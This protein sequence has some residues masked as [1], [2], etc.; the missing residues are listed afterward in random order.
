MQINYHDW[1]LKSHHYLTGTRDG[2]TTYNDTK[3][4]TMN[5]R[6]E[7]LIGL[8]SELL[9][10]QPYNVVGN[11]TAFKRLMDLLEKSNYTF[12]D[13]DQS[14]IKTYKMSL[15]N[16]MSSMVVNT[17]AVI[18]HYSSSDKKHVFHGATDHYYI[19][20]VPFNQLHF[21]DRDE[22]V[23][24]RL[25]EFHE[26][27]NGY[28]MDSDR[29]LSSYISDILGFTLLCTV[30]GFI[31]ND[32]K[33]AIDEKGFKFKIGWT[34]V[35]KAD[36]IIYK[37]D[38]TF[39]ADVD[40][41]KEEIT[42]MMETKYL[43][44]S[45]LKL[46]DHPELIGS[47]CIFHLCDSSVKN[48]VK[49][50]PNFGIMKSNGLDVTCVQERI[51]TDMEAGS[52]STVRFRIYALK[53]LFEIPDLYP[54]INFYSVIARKHIYDSK[55]NHITNP[56]GNYIITEYNVANDSSGNDCTPPISVDRTDDKLMTPFI[57]AV[58]ME[59]SLN[60]LWSDF[61]KMFDTYFQL[62]SDTYVTMIDKVKDAADNAYNKIAGIYAQYLNI[63]ITTN[64]VDNASKNAFDDFMEQ[65]S[66]YYEKIMAAPAM[67]D[68][69]IYNDICNSFPQLITA[70]P[71]V[72]R[73]NFVNVVTAPFK[74]E[75]TI[76][77]LKAAL[78]GNPGVGFFFDPHAS[79]RYH[80]DRS[81]DTMLKD[82]INRPISEQCFIA[83][84]YDS[85]EACWKFTCP[86]INHFK[87]ISNTFYI[88]DKKES[89]RT[90]KFLILY[91][92][93]ENTAEKTI[94]YFN[95]NQLMD[96]D[97]FMDEVEEHLGYI[98]YWN[99]ESRLMKLSKMMYGTN[100]VKTQISILS[101]ILDHKMNSDWLEEY[102]SIINYEM[103]NV[104]S[105]NV[106][107]GEYEI[108]A[109]FA[110]NFMFYTVSQLYDN[111]DQLQ[112]YFLRQL[113]GRQFHP[114][115][116]D[117]TVDKIDPQLS[118]ECINYS[119]ITK[120]PSIFST[121]DQNISVFPDGNDFAVYNGFPY[122]L[123][124][125]HSIHHMTSDNEYLY[126][127]NQYYDN[128]PLPLVS[129]TGI[130]KDYHVSFVN[131]TTN[132]I[133]H[134][135][136]Y[137]DPQVA[138]MMSLCI[139]ELAGII[140]HIQTNYKIT[141]DQTVAVNSAIQIIEKWSDRIESYI[142][143]GDVQFKMLNTLT[144]I[145][146]EQLFINWFKKTSSTGL[147]KLFTDI[148][149]VID[150]ARKVS[151]NS[152]PLEKFAQDVL[153]EIQYVH[154]N[155]GY[156]YD[157][158]RYA[159]A[160]YIHLKDINE[161]MSLKVAGNWAQTLRNFDQ[162]NSPTFTFDGMLIS[163]MISPIVKD[164]TERFKFAIVL[165]ELKQ[166][167]F[168]PN[169][170]TA[171]SQTVQTL[172][173][174]YEFDAW[175]DE[176]IPLIK[177]YFDTLIN[178]FMFDMY[179]IDDME[180][181]LYF[182]SVDVGAETPTFAVLTIPKTDPHVVV[183]SQQAV[184]ST[185]VTL[186]FRPIYDNGDIVTLHPVCNYAFFN[187]DDLTIDG[188]TVTMKFYFKDGSEANN[189][190]DAGL[191]IRFKKVSTSSDIMNQFEQYIGCQTI[192]LEV[193]N[194]HETFD[195]LPDGSILN[196]KHAKLHYELL[197]GNKFAPLDSDSEFVV[198]AH[199]GPHDKLFL[200]C[201]QLNR[202]A[203]TDMGGRPQ[204]TWF[205]KPC[206][207]MHLDIENGYMNSL[208]SGYFEGQTIY[209]CTDDGLCVFPLIITAVDHSTEH[210]FVEAK[211]DEFNAPWFRTSD[212]SVIQKYLNMV[213]PITCTIVDDNIRNFMDEYTEY[214]GPYYPIPQMS[215]TVE[216][217]SEWN[218]V[219]TLPGDP[220]Y[221][222]NNS[223]YVYTRLNWMFHD[224]IPN[225]IDGTINPMYHFLYLG[226]VAVNDVAR[227]A[228]INL[229]YHDFN[230]YTTPEMY[231]VLR[232]E[233][234]DHS[235]WKQ[236]HLTF[237]K[238]IGN[239]TLKIAELKEELAE[240][241][242]KLDLLIHPVLEKDS[243][244]MI[245]PGTVV[246]D[247][248]ISIEDC[249]R[250]WIVD[251]VLCDPIRVRLSHTDDK[252]PE[253]GDTVFIKPG[254]CWENDVPV[255]SWA[256]ECVWTVFRIKSDAVVDIEALYQTSTA[257]GSIEIKYLK[258]V[259][260]DE[261]NP[262]VYND[263]H[264]YPSYFD[265]PYILPADSVIQIQREYS[266]KE[267]ALKLHIEAI[268]RDIEYWEAFIKRMELYNTELETPTK[269][270]N[271]NSYD[272]AMIYI[273]NGRARMIPVRKTAL[274]DVI[275]GQAQIRL[276]DWENKRW[277]SPRDYIYSVIGYD[278]AHD[279][280]DDYL[281]PRVKST[282][283][284][285]F[286]DPTFNS[287][288][289]LVYLVYD[290][291]TPWSEIEPG[292]MECKV[293][294][295]PVMHVN[296][297]PLTQ[298]LYSKIRV[299]KHYDESETY[300]LINLFPIP[301][302]FPRQNGFLLVRPDRSGKYKYGSPIRFCDMCILANDTEMTYEDFDIYVRNPM[303][304][305][306]IP[307]YHI[308]KDYSVSI[309]VAIDGF[310]ENHHVLL[311]S[312][313]NDDVSGFNGVS[314]N[315]MF[316]GIT[317]INEGNPVITIT[318]STLPIGVTGTFTCTVVPD[319]TS[320]MSGGLVSVVVTE[321]KQ[322]SPL[323]DIKYMIR[324]ASPANSG[325]GY[326]ENYVRLMLQDSTLSREVFKTIS[327]DE[328]HVLG[329]RNLFADGYTPG[330][331]PLGPDGAMVTIDYEA[332]QTWSGESISTIVVDGS[333]AS[334]LTLNVSE[335]AI[336]P[337][338]EYRSTNWVNLYHDQEHRDIAYKIIPKQ[339]ILVPK[340]P[341]FNVLNISEVRLKNQYVLDSDGSD[342]IK[343]DTLDAPFTYYYDK[344]HDV[345]YPIG[346][347]LKNR[348][349][350]RLVIDTDT[351]T[352]VSTIRSNHISVCRYAS[353]VI[354]QDG[355]IDLTGYIPTPLSRDRYE[356]WVNGKY[357][358][359]PDII[360]LSPTSFQ[361]RNMTSLHNLEVIELVDDISDTELMP[362]GP[363]YVDL[364]G[365][366][367]GSYH[368]MLVY[369]ANIIDQSIKYQFNQSTKTDLDDYLASDVR[370]SGNRDY[371]P[372]ILSYVQIDEEEPTSY[373]ELYHIP[374][375]NGQTIFH[376]TTQTL[377][378]I[379]ITNKQVIDILD[380]TWKKEILNGMIPITHNGKLKTQSDATQFLHVIRR[381]DHFEIYTSGTFD[382]P[383]TLYLSTT[384]T[385]KIQNATTTVRIMPMLR[386]GTHV[387]LAPE[388]E[389]LWV[390]STV[391]D[392][393]PVQ[394]K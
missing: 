227:S 149:D 133:E 191:V 229:L 180:L 20:D 204:T 371:E 52:S 212:I 315:I 283:N 40:I 317:A 91:T 351:S 116:A 113:T 302:D 325:T 159:R 354:P 74:S 305:V 139:S 323:V 237:K 388:F 162:G 78:G 107:A 150:A 119:V 124:G 246:G 179:A 303:N 339:V 35:D 98:K 53:Y 186:I 170:P 62:Y 201:D 2:V 143:N 245:K 348:A 108:R 94:E 255:P 188:T 4:V 382:R 257:R 296:Q 93:T 118:S 41:P 270:Y 194:I 301:S 136:Y 79:E 295:K 61:E 7:T 350:E 198:N 361:L 152:N 25:H 19:I 364:N 320:P 3:W 167:V 262:S 57:D 231:P 214:E 13:M 178:N 123:D 11:Y 56:D 109:P 114:R 292:P 177:T 346:N 213:E 182:G 282:L 251:E 183:P 342:D 328:G 343:S 190:I 89:G 391:P 233:P 324:N 70:N 155:I 135:H 203:T 300:R 312:V 144:A 100:D 142:N 280:Y 210:G 264:A 252:L 240:Q 154:K 355:I 356:F 66:D 297:E 385:G 90:F 148:K 176:F 218:D 18:A 329:V 260:Q 121:S 208:G 272:A 277:L 279:V 153:T 359:D 12:E 163:N 102:P 225:R 26:T 341:T 21:G 43:S 192:P 65:L 140:S 226:D 377:G 161:P 9:K 77:R 222:V 389:N 99:V 370:A 73:S 32:W 147:M 199:S 45:W 376:A 106:G 294:F 360:I 14:L 88:R 16:A 85:D 266:K 289:I 379:E 331:Y 137:D 160:V 337:I 366:T 103:S 394:I 244:V 138:S 110:L 321:I 330:E 219:Y 69:A 95:D 344:K 169:F 347:V 129:D 38:N 310:E 27:E 338:E 234:D 156:D 269:W 171:L 126:M 22:F 71:D 362:K 238:N 232:E 285:L 168:N 318:S 311:V 265:P 50:T 392:T 164:D 83:F 291:N 151:T 72:Y 58:Y 256:L 349:S 202:Y 158:T 189:V 30:N 29:F 8:N 120:G 267:R 217:P 75:P 104:S 23:R 387:I 271:V 17:H 288:K 258:H 28:F 122:V 46:G 372:D 67:Y 286:T 51:K 357:V 60:L 15:Q 195:V 173:T 125:T 49:M 211:V 5:K 184:P 383:F 207:V 373:E 247:Q 47:R 39:V 326:G 33:V 353:H 80:S 87:G 249:Q 340:D 96:F 44:M 145:G 368:S 276:Y 268:E 59:D 363:V 223:E 386:A 304:S 381:D 68:E 10:Y 64:F 24:Q 322:P 314:S 134:I 274:R 369:K 248:Y 319:G 298:E 165:N 241:K 242:A 181:P 105:D 228:N 221:V 128:I 115:Y 333:A 34:Y 63:C 278:N 215:S 174:L 157:R 307:M 235:V 273:D 390:I 334:G 42:S 55:Y 287:K 185:N 166:D 31:T 358:D 216:I 193:Q 352:D 306:E 374:T 172:K 92:D 82:R 335:I 261:E 259:V 224:E 141:W 76:V 393:T 86:T 290:N 6:L 345:R 197:A 281:S 243:T 220:I 111:K 309:P 146:T 275:I 375:I 132:G 97:K 37:L 175:W 299:R 200:K 250:V 378:L 54:M 384:Q 205:F 254:S 284:I 117:L 332:T 263:G 187:G 84:R 101:R 48:S 206:Q 236:E 336:Q 239:A 127:F 81:R 112:A 316:E 365:N 230:S 36:F 209:A 253:I 131:L 293:V 1:F 130:D 313:K 367:Y 380:R 196:D 327:D 308:D